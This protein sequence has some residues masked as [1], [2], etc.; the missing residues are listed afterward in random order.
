MQISLLQCQSSRDVVAN[1]EFIESQLECLPREANEPQLV[2]LPECSL[3]FGG[4]ER[5]Q[6][7][8]AG[9]ER[10]SSLKSALGAL[11]KRYDVYLVAGTIPM[12]ADEGRVYSRCYLFDNS[13]E[14]LGQYDKLHLFDVDVA[15]GTKEYRESDT[16]CPGEHISVVDTPLGKIGLAVCYDLRFPELFRAMRLAGAEFIALPSAFTKVT[17]EAHWQS[18]IQARAI[19]TQCFLL[20]AA[21]WGQHNEGSRE[22]WGQSMIVDPW[23]Q[24]MAQRQ[25]GTG[26]IQA[27][28]DMLQLQRIR[29]QMPVMEHNRFA[30]PSLTAR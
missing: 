17:G 1:L 16:F 30:A 18:L 22:T 3:L 10:Q 27:K 2:V 7:Q 20:A 11:A 12:R 9:D 15:D 6:L 24:I 25:T 28:P 29:R 23:G 8:Y 26:W 13:G 5:Q 21:Q 4:H 19:E 14:V